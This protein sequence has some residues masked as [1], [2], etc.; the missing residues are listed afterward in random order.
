MRLIHGVVLA[1]AVLS[2]TACGKQAKKAEAPAQADA[3]SQ[4]A[5]AGSAAAPALAQGPSPASPTAAEEAHASNLAPPAQAGAELGQMAAGGGLAAGLAAKG[6][7]KAGGDIGKPASGSAPAVLGP[8]KLKAA[9]KFLQLTANAGGEVK[10]ACDEYVTPQIAAAEL[11]G[12]IGRAT[13]ITL[14]GGPSMPSCYGMTG[15]V[16]Y[17]LKSEG[18]AFKTI[19]QDNG[20]LAVMATSHN[21]VK[22][23]AV[24]GPG[25]EFPVYHWDG[26][27]YVKG[28]T[29]KDTEFPAPLN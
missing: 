22:D 4:P 3:A 13:L 6:T 1:A 5:Q 25:F 9:F 18:E 28:R 2:A 14:G 29:I 21:G 24:G 26:A 23:I 15:T 10:N 16:F 20:S 8:E 27:K 11:G 7:E 17:L 19:F 12:S